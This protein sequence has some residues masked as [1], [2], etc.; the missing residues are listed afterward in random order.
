MCLAMRAMNG[1]VILVILYFGIV[2]D[3]YFPAICYVDAFTAEGAF[4]HGPTYK[5]VDFVRSNVGVSA[6]NLMQPH[7]SAAK[8]QFHA[9]GIGSVGN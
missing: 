9:C 2:F 5:V 8:E 6:G 3:G 1:F 7:G 4:V